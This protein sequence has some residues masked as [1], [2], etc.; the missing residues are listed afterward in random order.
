M[1][2]RKGTTSPWA[3]RPLWFY[4]CGTLDGDRDMG[5]SL[6]RIVA[7]PEAVGSPAQ[8]RGETEEFKHLASRP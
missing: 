2:S 6:P 3:G 5:H 7:Q 1:E 4:Y 8:G